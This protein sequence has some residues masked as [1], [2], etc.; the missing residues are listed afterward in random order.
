MNGK[1]SLVIEGHSF[2]LLSVG[3]PAEVQ[4]AYNAFLDEVSV[5]YVRIA[6]FTSKSFQANCQYLPVSRDSTHSS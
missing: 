1:K 5:S 6:H 4:N 2:W 3:F